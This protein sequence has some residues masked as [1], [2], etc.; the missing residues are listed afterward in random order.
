[1]R[2]LHHHAIACGF[3]AITVILPATLQAQWF[4]YPAPE[5]PR[6]TDG[7]PILA[8]PSPRIANGRPDL[9]GFWR[10]RGVSL[11]L[12]PDDRMAWADAVFRERRNNYLKD[13]PFVTCLPWGPAAMISDGG[14][15]KML[16][17]EHQITMLWETLTYRQIF[18]DGRALP[19]D[20]NP[21]WMGYSVGR[22]DGDVLVVESTG[23]TERSW[24]D[25][26]GQPHSED[27]RITERYQRRD[28]GHMALLVTVDDPKTFKRPWH[29][30]F[31]LELDPDAQFLEYVCAENEKSRAHMVGL[32]S[33]AEL[34]GAN[35]D[36]AVLE[37][38]VGPYE[39]SRP[40]GSVVRVAI[41][42]EGGSLFFQR[43]GRAK[44]QLTA[45]S[46]TRFT[47]AA[48]YEFVADAQGVVTHFIIRAVE[49]EMKAI[50]Q[51]Q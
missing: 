21:T 17:S 5:V 16:Q 8:G 19:K 2:L 34:T 32:T 36:P 4:T 12:R 26:T 22:W 20:P 18:M 51:R 10:K 42:R 39:W 35:V 13:S 37:T 38:Y 40:D 23:F 30:T 15:Q 48:D 28:F 46:T 31:E 1:M 43:E 47:G 24:L 7:K 25:F 11:D 49:G 29:V 3:A 50:R 6:S 9:S 27:L 33:D 14:P 45:L 44:V 41:T